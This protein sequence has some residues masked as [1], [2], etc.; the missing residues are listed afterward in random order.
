[1]KVCCLG[2]VLLVIVLIQIYQIYQSGELCKEGFAVPPRQI[3]SDL[4]SYLKIGLS[5]GLSLTDESRLKSESSVT[6]TQ[7]RYNPK[8]NFGA[9]I[10]RTNRTECAESGN[11]HG[12]AVSS[13]SPPKI[14]IRYLSLPTT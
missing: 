8:N 9:E 1:M 5:G 13:P 6:D 14:D 10:A 12:C 7:R 2:L 4:Q 11:Y 3:D